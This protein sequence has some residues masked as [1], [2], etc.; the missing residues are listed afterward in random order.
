MDI[1]GG[2]GGFDFGGQGGASGTASDS[3]GSSNTPQLPEGF[4]VSGFGGGELPEGFDPSDFAGMEPPDGAAPEE[5]DAAAQESAQPAE[6]VSPAGESGGDT[7]APA[8]DSFPGTGTSAGGSS[9]G[10]LAQYGL[11]FAVFAAALLFAVLYRR[12]PRRR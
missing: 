1:G 9:G 7:G 6:T 3:A 12:K 11:S 5:T 2:G 10:A 4:D 8:F